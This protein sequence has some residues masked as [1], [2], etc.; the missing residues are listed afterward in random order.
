VEKLRIHA[1][2]EYESLQIQTNHERAFEAWARELKGQKK[3]ERE[4]T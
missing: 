2:D 1:Q 3:S 4:K